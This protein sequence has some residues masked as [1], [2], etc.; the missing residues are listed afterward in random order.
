MS[1]SCSASDRPGYAFL[2]VSLQSCVL[3]VRRIAADSPWWF[4]CPPGSP[5]LHAA[6]FSLRL[7]LSRLLLSVLRALLA[8][9]SHVGW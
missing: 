7:A 4:T 9:L 5:G 8:L 3:A 2:G 6:A 1:F